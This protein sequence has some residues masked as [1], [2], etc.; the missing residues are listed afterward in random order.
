VE[1]L[2]QI[3]SKID[4]FLLVLARVGGIFLIGPIFS[5]RV[6]PY[7]ARVL[8]T[9]ML[10][11]VLFSGLR[12]NA[13]VIPAQLGPFTLFLVSEMIIG[14]IIGFVAQF[15]FAAI[16]FAGQNI[17]FMM[18]FGIV[19][20]I[21]PVYGTTA[22]LVGSFKNILA[23]LIFLSTNSHHYIIAALYQSFENI[24]LFGLSVGKDVVQV[25]VQLFGN[26]LVT[27]MR[28]GMPV[29][30]ALFVAEIA[31]GLIARTMPQMPVFFVF[32][33]VKIFIGV[34]L[35]IIILPLYITTLQFL[36]DG[37]FEDTVRI[38]RMLN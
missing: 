24:P 25:M 8:M 23:L 16:Q 26:M 31:S 2:G 12:L 6:I 19:N 22:S 17:D 1:L 27:G 20:V 21:D 34:V 9:V 4:V 15:T 35:L 29:I 30:G 7:Q 5:N 38:L 37:N 18:G 32:I 13:P 11:M 3:A 10:A 33:P 28:L 36:F 14:L